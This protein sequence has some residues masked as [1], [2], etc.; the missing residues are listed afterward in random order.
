MGLTLVL[1]N[2]RL[3]LLPA[4]RHA[5]AARRRWASPI[6]VAVC[7]FAVGAAA[8]SG[9]ASTSSTGTTGTTTVPGAPTNLVATPGNGSGS[10]AFTAPS[11]G[12]SAITGYTASC[13]AGS[14]TVTG[15]SA[16]SPVAVSGLTNGTAYSCTVVAKNAA[17]TGAASA[18]VALTPVASTPAAGST[19]AIGCPLSNNSFNSSIKVNAY[20]VWNWSCGTVRTL[21]GNGI[22]EHAVTGG[23]FATPV[24]VQNISM[25]FSLTPSN[26]GTATQSGDVGYAW[27]SVKLDPGTAGTCTS[28]ATSTLPGGGCVAAAGTD[29]WR[30]E[31]LGGAFTFGTDENNAHVQPNGQYHYHGIP[32]GEIARLG[33]GTG[34]TLVAWA[35]DGFPI[36]ARYGYVDANNASSGTRVMRGSWQKKAT[37]DTGRP[38]IS[39]M[40]SPGL[41]CR[42]GA[43]SGLAGPPC[44]LRSGSVRTMR[45]PPESVPSPIAR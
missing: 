41:T 21:T 1:P 42:K 43:A 25:T 7:A 40:N 39:T 23:N 9:G 29:P 34:L 14:A 11:A 26:T 10:I 37:P 44:A 17:G 35:R 4:G 30:I 5:A 15:T 19:A 33:K 16:A 13:T 31:A 32:E 8:C 18:A 20:S 27:N 2:R 22:P 28:T 36:Y 38:S 3:L 6:A 24:G 12:G 45:H